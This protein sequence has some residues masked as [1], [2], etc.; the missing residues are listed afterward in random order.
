[1]GSTNL[2]T[3]DQEQQVIDAIRDAED[4]TSGEIRIHI[5]D[6]VS[7]D[8]LE[9]AKQI[10]HDLGMNETKRQNGVLIYIASGDRRA[11]IYGGNGID[12]ETEAGFWNQTL[13]ELIT[14]FKQQQF[15][16]GLVQTVG[17]VAKKL[18][19]FFPPDP[20]DVNELSNEISYKQNPEKQ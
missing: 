13:E 18:A 5:E 1:M 16:T 6:T 15:E 10:F 4:R 20:D 7:G 8:P 3:S 9:R 14:H 17:R 11:A 19:R 12:R 2:L